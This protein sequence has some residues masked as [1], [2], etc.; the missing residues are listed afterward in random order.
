MTAID[1]RTDDPD[2]LPRVA[3]RDAPVPDL[4]GTDGSAAPDLTHR[5]ILVIFSGLMAGMLLA[6]LDGTIV[7]TAMPTIVG[8][9]GGIQHYS[10]PATAYLLTTTVATPLYGKLSDLYGRKLLFQ[11]AIVIFIVGSVLCGLSQSM[12]QLIGA[13]G[14]QGIGAGG[15]MAMAFAILG[16]VISPRQRG[17][18]TGYLGSV[19]AFASVVGPFLGGFLVDSLSWR[20]VFLVNVPVGLAAL[21]ITS[22]V[23]KLPVV[24][25]DHAIDWVGAA[26]LV[27]GVTSLL[28]GLVWGGTEYAWSSPTIRGLLAGFAACLAVFLWWESRTPEPILPLRLFRNRVFTVSTVLSLIIGAAMYG[29]LMFLPLFLQ[30]VTGASATNSGLLLLPLMAGM[31]TTSIVSGR[32]IAHT[33]RY[34]KWPVG[35]TAVA[36][37]GMVFLSTMDENTTRL[38]SSLYMLLLGLGVGMVMQVL[39]LAAQNAADF[40]DMGVVT[41]A[42]N[43]FRSLG[44]VVGVAVFGAIMSATLLP[45]LAERIPPE[46]QAAGASGDVSQLLNEPDKI[47]ELPPVIAD[48]VITSLRIAIDRVFLWVVPVLLVGFALTWF[49]PERR[50]RETSAVS[51]IAALV[52]E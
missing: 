50:L 5:E 46:V 25:R 4:T 38:E 18:Y 29:A 20:W 49:L 32:V 14:I 19:F 9:L 2:E 6:A 39:I 33:G 12:L 52:P 36:A 10:W 34:K 16:D 7:A 27:G 23:L 11:A 31:M 42:V 21:G 15:L 40:G 48:A 3:E 17:R 8:D 44:G 22:A 41:S 43:F 51:D 13:R 37:V 1:T 28:L 47:Q 35:G 26:L 30:V 45:A 24:R